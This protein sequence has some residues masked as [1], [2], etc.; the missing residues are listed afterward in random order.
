VEKSGDVTPVPVAVIHVEPLSVCQRYVT[1]AGAATTWNVIVVLRTVVMLTGCCVID[2][3]GVT[4]TTALPDA[5]PP[6][7]F[8]SVTAVIV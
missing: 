6:A 8:A 7:Q 2:G 4:V 1:P 5:V 3:A